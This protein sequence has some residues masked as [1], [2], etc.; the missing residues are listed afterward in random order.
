MKSWTINRRIAFAFACLLA[1]VAVGCALSIVFL[2][3]VAS[4]SRSVASVSLPASIAAQQVAVRTGHAES[5]ILRILAAKT[6]EDRASIASEVASN[7]SKD[8]AAYDVLAKTLVDASDKS[9]LDDVVSLRS[10]F[11]SIR[12]RVLGLAD[13]GH[14]DAATALYASEGRP[15][16]VAY[17]DSLARLCETSVSRIQSS[18]ESL[19][20]TVRRSIWITLAGVACVLILGIGLSVLITRSL[21]Q[22][23]VHL[24]SAVNEASAQISAASAQVSSASQSLAESSSEQAAS[25]EET[26]ASLEEISSMTK[27]NADSA[28]NARSI[29]EESSR[30]TEVGTREMSEMV[31]AMAAIK[32][33]SD[34]IAKIIKTIDEIAFQTNILA[35]NAAVEAARAGETGA[36]FAVVAD[37]VRN[38][39][40]RAATAAK[41]TAEKIDDSIAKSER[42]VEISARVANGLREITEKTRKV[43]E[44]IGEIASAS[45]EQNQGLGQISSAITQMDTVT[46]GNA[47]S[48]EETAAAAEELS[49]QAASLLDSVA[50]LS[51]LVGISTTA[52]TRE[53]RAPEAKAPVSAKPARTSTV[54][55]S[56]SALAPK[57]RGQEPGLLGGTNGTNGRS[58]GPNGHSNGSNGHA[59]GT[60]GHSEGANGHDDFFMDS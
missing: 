45:K 23:L 20:A 37:E 16:Y 44:L 48:A 38:L 43:N 42:G 39:A 56:R 10:K 40:Q 26:S 54:S 47:G 60:N 12:E 55:V 32:S 3:G 41:E 9:L 7:K 13:E 25:L 8:D 35:L 30:A 28:E 57:H 59:N 14:V 1:F 22:V 53:M 31:D 50:E 52:A 27:R 21:N 24:T 4:E 36:G 2:G 17:V 33:S 5:N 18:T 51:G 58:H 29:S 34:N 19:D 46:Q 49:S 11:L 6:A 15:A